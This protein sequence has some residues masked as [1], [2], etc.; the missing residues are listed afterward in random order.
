M[1]QSTQRYT[2]FVGSALSSPQSSA[3]RKH[4][5]REREFIRSVQ[6]TVR[7]NR[8]TI[9]LYEQKVTSRRD[10]WFHDFSKNL[11]YW[12]SKIW[13][14]RCVASYHYHV[15]LGYQNCHSTRFEEPMTYIAHAQ[16]HWQNFSY[17]KN[18]WIDWHLQA[19]ILSVA[20]KDVYC[21]WGTPDGLNHKQNF[22]TP[23]SVWIKI[24]WVNFND[25]LWRAN[26]WGI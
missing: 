15:N 19:K 10:S 8:G 16:K 21:T 4:V 6:E 9:Q 13:G 20:F 22:L 5:W 14:E 12:K 3:S 1:V 24:P 11:F 25:S 26:L 7:W 2:N 18:G 17:A 23:K